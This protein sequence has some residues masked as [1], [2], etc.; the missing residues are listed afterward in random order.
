VVP[1]TDALRSLADLARANFDQPVELG[2]FKPPKH[3]H[4]LP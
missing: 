3:Y 1:L 2:H 4:V